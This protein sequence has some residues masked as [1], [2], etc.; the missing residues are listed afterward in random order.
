MKVLVVDVGGTSVK[1][2]ACGQVESRKFRSGPQMTP[3][4]MVSGVKALA[5]GWK[6]DVVSIG[7]PGRVLRGK[8]MSEPH[9]LAAGWV[10]FDFEAAFDR[11]V[12]LLNDAAMQALGS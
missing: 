1:I 3:R 5:G 8:V 11:P 7:Y 12:K 4:Q 10:R 9:N 2:L 6:Y